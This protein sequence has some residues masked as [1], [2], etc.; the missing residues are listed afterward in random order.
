M[1]GIES[2]RGAPVVVVGTDGSPTSQAAAAEAGAILPDDAEIHLVTVVEEIDEASEMAG[3]IEGPLGTPE[4]VREERREVHVAGDADLARTARAFGAR[5]VHEHLLEGA[6][7]GE[8]LCAFAD[9]LGAQLLVVGSHGRGLLARVVL[10]SVS[11]HVVHH[12]P[13]PVLV[14]PRET[15]A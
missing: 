9:E 3:G 4:Q 7:A 8:A 13:C 2:P 10:G 6:H 1:T 12:A 5:P 11:Q 14:V 15:E